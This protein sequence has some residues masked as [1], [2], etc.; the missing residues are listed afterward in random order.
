MLCKVNEDGSLSEVAS[1]GNLGGWEEYTEMVNNVDGTPTN[2]KAYINRELHEFQLVMEVATTYNNEGI[3]TK[4]G[5]GTLI[6]N[7]PKPLLGG[8]AIPMYY[9]DN[10]FITNDTYQ[11]RAWARS[12]GTIASSFI[13]RDIT[14]TSY[15]DIIFVVSA[16]YTYVD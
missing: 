15:K 2:F 10:S 13:T 7:I 14:D 1:N 4:D 5:S 3:K 8:Q 9:W 12:N 11:A 16:R 6:T